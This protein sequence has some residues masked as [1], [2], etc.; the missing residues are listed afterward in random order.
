MKPPPITLAFLGL[1]FSIKDFILS[2]SFMFHKVNTFS[3][4]IPSIG[5]FMGLEPVEIIS[6]S[7]F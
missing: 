3:F 5:G 2:V 7:Y 4:S 1:F 6:L